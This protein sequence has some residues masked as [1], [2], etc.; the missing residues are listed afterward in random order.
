MQLHIFDFDGTIF[1]SPTPS[2]RLKT[3]PKGNLYAKLMRPLQ[4]GGLGW[5]QSLSTLSPP[6]VP[7]V[8]PIE[9]WYVAPVMQRLRELKHYCANAA[10]AGDSVP[11]KVYVLTGRDEKYR[12]RMEQILRHA[13]L[14]ELVSDVFLKPHETYGTVKYKLEAFYTLIARHRPEHVYYYEDRA[15]Q[16]AKLLAGIQLLSRAVHANEPA[17]FHT[18]SL[19]LHKSGELHPIPPD[20]VHPDE[21]TLKPCNAALRW[22]EETQRRASPDP[23]KSI[24]PFTFTLIMIDPELTARCESILTSKAE[25]ALVA[26]L[27]YEREA[28]NAS[29]PAPPPQRSSTGREMHHSYKK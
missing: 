5:F 6:V 20:G 25:D 9:E 21:G 4:D 7:E 12:G 13:G 1:C 22:W 16:G 26:Q 24:A 8:P 23:L 14:N 2:V 28:Y 15:E 11:V 17:S 29:H 10:A 27:R 19:M 18:Y 3:L